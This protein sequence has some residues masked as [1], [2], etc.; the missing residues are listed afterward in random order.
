[1]GEHS[2]VAPSSAERWVKC[3]GSVALEA[4][5]PD[6]DTDESREG[7]AAHWFLE[8]VLVSPKE[9]FS[10]EEWVGRLAPNDWP[11]DGDMIEA[12]LYVRDTIIGQIGIDSMKDLRVETKIDIPRIHELCFG[13]VDIFY[14]DAKLKRLYIWDYKYGHKFISA[15]ENWQLI[16]YAAGL[17]PIPDEDWEVVFEI[18]QPRCYHGDRDEQRWKVAANLLR[19]HIN[20]LY[21]A[22][23][24]AL[25]ANAE[26]K[27]G[28]HCLYCRARHSCASAR[29]SVLTAMDYINKPQPETLSEQALEVEMKLLIRAEKA[30]AARK[31]AIEPMLEA[32]LRKGASIQ[33]FR[34]DNRK[35]QRRWTQP[36]DVIIAIGQCYEADLREPTKVLTPA[37]A[38]KNLK[39]IGV[40][41]DV[42]KPYIETP[43]TGVKLVEDDGSRARFLFLNN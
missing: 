18:F 28:R 3:T 13:T 7:T 29:E 24:L 16:A 21:T 6:P 11:I 31:S 41:V 33:G 17:I 12:A 10:I 23:H 27:S 43:N 30:L 42:I 40:D 2:I 14:V 38:E 35:G 5:F 39:K 9:Y 1:M 26:L 22:S 4:L 37:Q 25:S 8:Q 36:D 20:Q 32:A 34:L 19:G 15:F